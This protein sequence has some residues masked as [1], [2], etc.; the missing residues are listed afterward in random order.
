MVAVDPCDGIGA[1]KVERKP[2]GILSV[3]DCR[4]LMT[5]AHDHDPELLAPLTLSLFV[6]LRSEEVE[7]L[8]WSAVKLASGL[9]DIPASVSKTNQRRLSEI[10]P[11][12]A[13]WLKL[14]HGMPSK[15][16]R[17]RLDVVV[18]KAGIPWPSNCLRHSFCSY[19][20]PVHGV[21]KTAANAGHSER[22]LLSNYREC[23]TPED[24]R[25][26][27]GIAPDGNTPGRG[28]AAR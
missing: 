27:W 7:R 14:C 28:T 24:A 16:L 8:E 5:A 13:A 17:R 19:S 3:A 22:V 10:S 2:P 6:G 23:V 9:V 11:N 4:K 26:F 12:A 21:V 1:V 25:E 15:N 18:A 20:L